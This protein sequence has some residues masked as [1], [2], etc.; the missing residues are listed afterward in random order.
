MVCYCAT[1]STSLVLPFYLNAS[2]DV[3]LQAQTKLQELNAAVADKVFG[4]DTKVRMLV[5]GGVAHDLVLIDLLTQQFE[6][7]LVKFSTLPPS[8]SFVLPPLLISLPTPTSLAI[9]FHIFHSG[10]C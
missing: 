1:V 10:I 3:Y 6:N 2:N 9:L 7:R 4:T 8:S 5:V